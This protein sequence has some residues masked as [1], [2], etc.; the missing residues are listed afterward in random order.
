[1]KLEKGKKQHMVAKSNA[2]AKYSI[3]GSTSE[4]IW[5]WAL[6][7]ELKYFRIFWRYKIVLWFQV[8]MYIEVC[9]HFVKTKV[10]NNTICIPFFQSDQQLAN[11]CT[12][13]LATA[14]FWEMLSKLF[15][16]NLFATTWGEYWW[17]D[18]LQLQMM[19]YVI[20]LCSY[21]Y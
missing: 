18:G 7:K 9:C 16:L 13:S 15:S 6:W 4:I 3:M 12:R 21:K 17:T 8:V 1:M 11:K 20:H 19:Q 2:E 10:Q 14:K 5:M